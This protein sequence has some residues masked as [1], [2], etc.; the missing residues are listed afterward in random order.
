MDNKAITD[1]YTRA[2][3]AKTNNHSNREILVPFMKELSRYNN[4]NF[5]TA[6]YFD[7]LYFGCKGEY[8][9]AAYSYPQVGDICFSDIVVST[10]GL[11]T[12]TVNAGDYED[13]PDNFDEYYTYDTDYQY[14]Y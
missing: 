2:V 10:T 12:F 9:L 13:P 7:N 5:E 8:W 6:R 14:K 1:I 4:I 11:L 3:L